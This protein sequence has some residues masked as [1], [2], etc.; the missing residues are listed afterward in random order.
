MQYV[1]IQYSM[2]Q[3]NIDIR[4]Y[5]HIAMFVVLLQKEWTGLYAPRFSY[6]NINS[7]LHPYYSLLRCHNLDTHIAISQY[8][9]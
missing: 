7:F 1:A 9:V 8:T 2:A 3:E 4:V 6:N 5:I